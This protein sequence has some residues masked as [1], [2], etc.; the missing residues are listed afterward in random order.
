MTSLGDFRITVAGFE[1][2]VFK[3]RQTGLERCV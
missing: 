1:C 2:N 3:A